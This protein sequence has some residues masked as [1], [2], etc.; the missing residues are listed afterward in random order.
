MRRGFPQI[1]LIAKVERTRENF[2]KYSDRSSGEISR[3]E[4]Y[5]IG[6]GLT[7]NPDLQNDK[8]TA[9]HRSLEIVGVIGLKN[10]GA[11][12]SD[13]RTLRRVLG[14]TAA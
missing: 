5:L 3:L 7:K 10:K 9:F 1:H 2:C 8:M 12:T 13:A 14:L 6:M 11:R 4:T